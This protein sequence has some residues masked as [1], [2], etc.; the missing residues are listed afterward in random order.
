MTNQMWF[1]NLHNQPT[2]EPKIIL[3]DVEVLWPIKWDSQICITK[4]TTDNNYSLRCRGFMTNQMGFSNLHNEPTKERKII[5]NN[6]INLFHVE[7]L[8]PNTCD[9]QICITN[10]NNQPTKNY[11]LRCRFMSNQQWFSNLHNQPTNQKLF[12]RCRSFMTNQIWFSN[13]HY[14]TNN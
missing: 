3:F 1:T 11:S 13:L 6:I 10:Q 2:N 4:Q 5:L 9:S 14:Q 7:V 8:R 12:Y